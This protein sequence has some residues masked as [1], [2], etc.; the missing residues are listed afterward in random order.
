MIPTMKV[1]AYK[2]HKI[3]VGEDIYAILD[4]YLPKLEEKTVVAIA[5]KIISLA[6]KDVIKKE[7]GMTKRDLI[8]HVTDYYLGND[9]AMKYNQIISIKEHTLTAS[10][11][12]DESNG[13][14]YFILWPKNVQEITNRIWEHLRKKHGVQNLGVII[15]DSRTT[16][17]RWG[18]TAISL[19]WCGV[20][21]LKNYIGEPDIY[22]HILQAEKTSIVDSLAT[23]AT[24]V[25]GEGNEQQPL[26]IIE[27]VDFVSF[28]NRVPTEKELNDLQIDI[29]D[30]LFEPLLTSVKW[31]RGKKE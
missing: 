20:E 10:G 21:P 23:A 18:V 29:K 24:V 8:P 2:T 27:D 6:Q 19:A 26:A 16:P 28:Q 14:G 31:E 9:Y 7:N 1:T 25:A 22:G 13:N 17:L 5:S 12:I 15:T 4:R 30:D 3:A 11:G